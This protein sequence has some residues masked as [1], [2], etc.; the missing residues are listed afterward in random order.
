MRNLH[1]SCSHENTVENAE[2][3]LERLLEWSESTCAC[4]RL[5]PA[6]L[7]AKAEESRDPLKRELAARYAAVL[8]L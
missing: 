8:G 4:D 3:A 2:D 6:E 5:S 1:M 7:L